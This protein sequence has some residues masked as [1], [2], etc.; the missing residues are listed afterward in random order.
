MIG[1]RV[2]Y[3]ISI[4]YTSPVYFSHRAICISLDGQYLSTC[5]TVNG[6]SKYLVSGKYSTIDSPNCMGG[7]AT[8]VQYSLQYVGESKCGELLI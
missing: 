3:L 6:I 8:V 1:Y 5:N 7:H 4:T 2:H